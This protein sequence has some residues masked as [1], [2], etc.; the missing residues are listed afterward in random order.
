MR[1]LPTSSSIA[2]ARKPTASEPTMSLLTAWLLVGAGI[3]CE[4]VGASLL[5]ASDGF[6]KVLETVGVLV[7]YGIALLCLSRAIEVLPLGVAIAVWAG[8]GV[9]ATALMGILLF[10]EKPTTSGSFSL[11]LIVLGIVLVGLFTGGG[12]L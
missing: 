8:V 7:F 5:K 12:S 3:V 10:G 6:S 11:G 2:G 1:W 9:A 4:L